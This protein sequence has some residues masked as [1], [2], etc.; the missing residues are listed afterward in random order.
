MREGKKDTN[1]LYWF[2]SQ[3]ES[4]SSPLA[5]PRDFHYNLTRLQMLKLTS[6]RLLK[7]TIRMKD[8]THLIYYKRCLQNTTQLLKDND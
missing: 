3:N 2:L 4:T 5:L 8:I 6:K 7:L 1:N